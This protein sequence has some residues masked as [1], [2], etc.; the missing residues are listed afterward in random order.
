MLSKRFLSLILCASLMSCSVP[1]TAL[2]SESE[3]HTEFETETESE[4]ETDTIYDDMPETESSVAYETETESDITETE[5]ETMTGTETDI[6]ESETETMSDMAET[7]TETMTGTDETVIYTQE[8]DTDDDTFYESDTDIISAAK[9]FNELAAQKTLMALL[10]R[11]KAYEVRQKPSADSSVIAAIKSGHTLYVKGME[12]ADN[13]IWYKAEFGIN[14]DVYSG[15]IEAEYLAYSDEDWKNIGKSFDNAL[16]KSNSLDIA[17]EL[18]A[19]PAA[20]RDKLEA[21]KELH[22]DW[23]FVAMETGLDF[24]TVVSNEMGD[25]SLIQKTSSNT[26]KGWVGEAYGSG[27]YYAT[28]DAVEYY[29]NPVNF[30]TENYIFQFEQLTFNSSYH[31][32]QS[33]QDFLGNT[34]MKGTLSDDEQE[35]SYA[36]AFY[37][38]GKERRLSPIHLASRVYQEQGSGKSALISGTYS[39]Y[40]GY[41]NYFNVKA[42]GTT[43]KEIIESGLAYAKEKGWNTRYKSLSGGADTIGNNYILKGQDTLYLEKFNVDGSYHKLYTH[44][45]MQNIQAPA[46]ESLSTKKM[47]ANAGSLD[48]AFVF[49][50]PV[51]ENM[52]NDLHLENIMLDKASL[53]LQTPDSVTGSTS[54][55]ES[56]DTLSLSF[57]PSDTTDEL[58]ITWSSLNPEIASVTSEGSFAE[59]NAISEGLTV[60]TA[61][62][63]DVTTET[64]ISADCQVKVLSPV[65]SAESCTVIFMDSDNSTVLKK[66]N[67][68]YGETI[69]KTDFPEMADK[70]NGLFAGWFTAKGGNGFC[71]DD[72]TVLSEEEIVLYPYFSE[73]G[74][75]LYVLPVSDYIYTGYAIKPE[76]KVYD[77]IA[78]AD[79]GYRLIELEKGKDYTV[80]YKNNKNVNTDKSTSP[81]VIIK[82]KG[83]YSGTE[84]AYFNILP[85]SLSESEA[86]ISADNITLAYNGKTQKPTP[87]VYR[88]GKKLSV[89]KDFTVSYPETASGSYTDTGSYPVM[90]TGINGYTGNRT[91]YVKITSDILINKVKVAK[92]PNQVYDEALVNSKKGIIPESI[93]VTYGER[94]LVEG[95]DYTISY[96]N[97]FSVGTATAYITAK[98]GSGFA[99]TKSITYKITGIPISRAAVS[100]IV[101][102]T[103]TGTEKDVLQENITLSIDGKILKENS[104]YTVSYSNTSKAGTASITF[105]GINA[106]SGQLKKTYKILP[107]DIRSNGSNNTGSGFSLTY[108]AQDSPDSPIKIKSLSEISSPYVKNRTCPNVQ[109]YYNDTQLKQGTD[110]TVKYSNNNQLS[111]NVTDST[112]LPAITVTGKGNFTGSLVGTW[113]ITDGEFDNENNKVKLSLKDVVYKNVPG[114]FKTAVTL[115]DANGAKLSAGKDY[116]A[117]IIF[118]YE[119][120]TTVNTADAGFVNRKAGDL[121]DENDIPDAGTIIRVTVKGMGAYEGN[122]NAVLSGTYRI[123]SAD[124]SKA[125]VTVRAK[126]YENGDNI[127]LTNDDIEVTLNGKSL[128]FGEHYIIDESTY[129]NNQKKGKATVTIKGIGSNYGGE[130]KITFT[131]TS[132]LLS[133]WKNLL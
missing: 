103:Y 15:Y 33:I 16:I 3:L 88:S 104:D 81:T 11:T 69:S 59:V 71:Y 110:Y 83:N 98:N 76:V 75:G 9:A 24:N 99:G 10:Y 14:G 58:N 25:K 131:I 36:Q 8:Y 84:Y 91:V 85:K 133:W 18:E 19:F 7:E 120:D 21:L 27:W 2:A 132:K 87:V 40:E 37:E 56:S 38:I 78:D 12:I 22:P 5:T 42:S 28:K 68:P 100:G 130:K 64:T 90:I 54:D 77:S 125:K 128:T 55:L 29:I 17:A 20:Y 61:V 127:F 30:L 23:S 32:T 117:D 35:R 108:S 41:Y 50:I 70:D 123:I 49:K 62:V 106:Y 79:G 51:Y 4:T 53:I 80:S 47:Y 109:L 118:S 66:I 6:T 107:L 119:N 95:T 121:T 57:Q 124:I 112:K 43:E 86:D 96:K 115:T 116:D 67:V 52:S 1:Y 65:S 102:K 82:G 26:E 73:Q 48:C 74:K 34:F 97:N 46:S 72:T 126:A 94:T 122:G 129:S 44:Q 39:G 89:K 114:K 45:Y 101:T 60:I 13:N 111:A 92:I 63:Y 93:T 113:K 105:K 31:S